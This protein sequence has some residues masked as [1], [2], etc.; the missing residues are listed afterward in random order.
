MVR[1]FGIMTSLEGKL[2]GERKCINK[3]GGDPRNSGGCVWGGGGGY[4]IDY[5]RLYTEW[6]QKHTQ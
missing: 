1:N 6:A 2:G 4:T 5:P 3:I